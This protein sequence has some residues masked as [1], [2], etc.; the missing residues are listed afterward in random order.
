MSGRPPEQGSGIAIVGMAGRFP[1]A[2]TVERFWRNLVEGRESISTFSRDEL[3]AAGVPDH[4]A[5]DRAYVPAAG[6]LEDV[7]GIDL[8][9]FAMTPGEAAVI[10]PQHR[11]FLECAWE[12]LEHAGCMTPDG[13]R[14]TAVFASTD[15]NTYLPF[16]VMPRL[17]EA[18][19]ATAAQVE[20]GNDKDFL[21]TRVSYKLDLRGPSVVVQTACSSSLVAVHMA[22]EALSSGACDLAVAGGSRIHVPLTEGHLHHEGGVAAAEPHCRAFDAAASGTIRGNGV[23]VVVL[24]RLDD[25]IEDRDRIVAV[26]LGSAINNDGSGKVGFTAPSVAG[27]RAVIRE[28]LAVAGVAPYEVAYVETHGTGTALGDPIEVEALAGALD[29]R[30]R[31]RPPCVLGAVKTNV[32]HLGSTAGVTGLI[33]AALSLERGTIP[34]TLHFTSPNPELRLDETRFVVATGATPWPRTAGRRRVAGVSSFG[35]G[36]TNCHLVLAEAP[37]AVKEPAPV[38]EPAL[39]TLSAATPSALRAAAADLAADL[40][41]RRHPLA[42]VALTL[43]VGRRSLDRRWAAVVRS[44]ED[45]ATRLRD[46]AASAGGSDGEAAGVCMLFPGQGAEFPGMARDA[47]ARHPSFARDIATCA[48]ALRELAGIDLYAFLE[49]AGRPAGPARTAAVQPALFAL[50][51]CLARLWTDWGVRPTALVGS[52]VGEYAAA[53]VAGVFTLEE[54]LALTVARGRAMAA[55]PPG[56]MVVVRAGEEEV[57][58]LLDGDLAI[59]AVNAPRATVVAGSP[60]AVAAL[61]RRLRSAGLASVRTRV[62]HAFHTPA[63]L[64]AAEPLAAAF[65][66]VALRPPRLPCYS[67]RTG[68]RLTDAEATSASYWV[69]QAASPVRFMDCVRSAGLGG[70]LFLLEMGPGRSLGRWARETLGVPASR[71]GSALGGG[72]ADERT[73]ALAA[74]GGSWAAGGRVAWERLARGGAGRK[75]R[76]PTYPFERTRCWF[77]ERQAAAPPSEPAPAAPPAARAGAPDVERLV[78]EIVADVLGVAAGSVPTDVALIEQGLESL[79]LLEVAE[80]VRQRLGVRVTLADL[81]D[82]LSTVGALARR[83]AAA[84]GA[85]LE[86]APEAPALPGPPVPVTVPFAAPSRE[87]T[88][89]D[90]QRAFLARFVPEYVRRTARSKAAN[91]RHRRPHADPRSSAGFRSAWKELVY[92]IVSDRAE[93]AWIWDLDG[94]RYVDLTMSFG[95]GLFG[96]SPGFVRRALA[97]Q[98]ERSIA[99]GPQSALAGAVAERLC[100]LTGFDRTVFT[101]SGTE[102]VMTA[103]RLARAAT[104]RDRIAIFQGSYHGAFDGVLARARRAGEA[105]AAPLALGVPASLVRDVVVLEYGSDDALRFVAEAGETVAAVIAEPVQSRNPGRQPVEFLRRLRAATRSSGTLLVLDEMITGFR[106]H[107]GGVN[108]LWGIDADV[109]TYGKVLG[110]GMPVGAVAGRR[111]VLDL[112][113]GGDWRYGD[114]SRPE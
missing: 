38:E 77:G 104:R 74:L 73:A 82:D 78:V 3:R 24:K 28:A 8:E 108:A 86:P 67:S 111:A 26:I 9:L 37:A 36:G 107:P 19:P 65:A 31:D 92:P 11:L 39:L 42:D 103:V 51:F 102:A 54:G 81:L 109:A 93:G 110:G 100:R 17:G 1:G 114:D 95:V 63:L 89:T 99:V 56:A 25:A 21:A 45:A 27:Q 43:Q 23:G 70:D 112:I 69:E 6:I 71:V 14:R 15:L 44:R 64:A 72:P 83:A 5:G 66:G 58:P 75:I 20:F 59:A 10:D 80:Q 76:L 13:E 4:V 52:S 88:L 34:G 90:P 55:L 32:G 60:P 113:D 101:N 48:T 79:A 84:G 57:R 18:G 41:E 29:A 7:A 96:H 61:E 105:S 12:A 22:C 97:A 53:A 35:I 49:T 30:R 2:P 106:C 68:R 47:L 46:L 98:L 40:E 33:K 87:G 16:V 62:E 94:N 85:P 50:E 91:E